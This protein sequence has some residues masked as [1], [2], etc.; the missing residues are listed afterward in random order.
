MHANNPNGPTRLHRT[1]VDHINT[2]AYRTD[3]SLTA[4]P[5][6][7]PGEPQTV[8]ARP[9]LAGGLVGASEV[10]RPRSLE[11]LVDTADLVVRGHVTTV[12]P[13]RAFGPAHHRLH[14]AAVTIEVRELLAGRAAGSRSAT[15]LLEVP[16]LDGPDQLGRI[17]QTMLGSERVLFLRNKGT[18]TA[19]AALPLADRLAERAYHRLVTFGSELI[20]ADSVA[21]APPDES[22]VLE[23]L[24]G[25]PF[26]EAVDRVRQAGTP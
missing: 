26:D 20:S 11:G 2:Y 3:R 4:P 18:S 10:E 19:A 25:L 1:D 22:G 15:V 17:R 8:E 24:H 9:R 13:G 7:Q 16:L 21:M 14:Y 23:S 12:E 5:I 6:L